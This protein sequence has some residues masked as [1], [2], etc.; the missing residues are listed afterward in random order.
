MTSI[1]TTVSNNKIMRD[2]V[3]VIIL[4]PLVSLGTAI[5]ISYLTEVIFLT[6]SLNQFLQLQILV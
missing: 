3:L 4:F 2:T 1:L 6:P 5:A